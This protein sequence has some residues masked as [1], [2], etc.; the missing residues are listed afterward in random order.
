MKESLN[1]I[2]ARL[3]NENK[4]FKRDLALIKSANTK[5][6]ELLSNKINE[7]KANAIE[8]EKSNDKETLCTENNINKINK[9]YIENQG[10]TKKNLEYLVAYMDNLNKQV[11]ELK[12]TSV[13]QQQ[14]TKNN[15]KIQEL[16]SNK[17]NELSADLIN[18]KKSNDKYISELKN[19]I[20]GS[21]HNINVIKKEFG[22]KHHDL[23]LT[24]TELTKDLGKET[25]CTENNINKIKKELVESKSDANNK[26][27]GLNEDLHTLSDNVLKLNITLTSNGK[28]LKSSIG[29]YNDLSDYV[30]ELKNE[31]TRLSNEINLHDKNSNKEMSNLKSANLTA[32]K[33]VTDLTEVVSGLNKKVYGLGNAIKNK[34]NDSLKGIEATN[35]KIEDLNKCNLNNIS[36]LKNEIERL[37]GMIKALKTNPIKAFTDKD[38]NDLIVK[39]V[40]EP[41]VTN[42]YKGKK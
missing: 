12:N 14:A 39:N 40:T 24:I 30:S 38:I 5:S 8:S 42:L 4:S 41:F 18:G 9:E 26:L 10:H 6:Q 36:E 32:K 11:I 35:Q 7:L 21:S 13:N 28:I 22:K 34:D 20:E 29:N 16:L 15:K 1:D 31:T 3:D 27:R 33:T 2:I 25:L 19:E 37:K 17:I 23:S